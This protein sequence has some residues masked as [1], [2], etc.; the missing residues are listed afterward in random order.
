MKLVDMLLLSLAAVFVIIGIYEV[1]TLGFGHAY[2]A[3]MLSFGFF[4]IYT[5]RKKK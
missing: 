2:W 5:Y 1:M 4:F 3:I